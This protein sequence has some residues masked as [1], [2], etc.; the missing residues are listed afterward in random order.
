MAMKMI[1]NGNG[2]AQSI[3]NDNTWGMPRA[4]AMVMVMEMPRASEMVMVMVLV[5]ITD[6]W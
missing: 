1:L 6:H 5:I 3:S 2:V 4:S